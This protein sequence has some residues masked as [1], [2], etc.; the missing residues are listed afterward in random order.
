MKV[1]QGAAPFSFLALCLLLALLSACS[2]PP[3]AP[4]SGATEGSEA[5]RGERALFLPVGAGAGDH[6]VSRPRP[7][8]LPGHDPTVLARKVVRI[9]FEAITADAGDATATAPK[10]GIELFGETA[11]IVR[12]RI[13]KRGPGDY[14]WVG[15]AVDAP[16]GTVVLTVGGGFLFGRIEYGED[17][18]KIEP[19]GGGPEHHLLKIDRS[20]ARPFGQ[21]VLVPGESERGE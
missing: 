16:G 19:V 10:V 4:L 18:Y 5:Y 7:L 2:S 1:F 17:V 3:S 21:D 11:H 12:T 15:T 20:R 13:E 6:D 8:P 14:T 9:D